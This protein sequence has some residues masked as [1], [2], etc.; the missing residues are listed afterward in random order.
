MASKNEAESKIL[1]ISIWG[2]LTFSVIGV[3]FGVVFSSE[4]IL[5]EGLFSLFSVIT[6]YITL[7]I[8]QYIHKKDRFNF[9][10]GK[11]TLEPMV[12]LIQYL[13]LS[14]FLVYALWDAIYGLATGGSDVHLLGAILYLVVSI[15]V[16]YVIVG[17]MKKI[18]KEN[19]SPLIDS[20]VFQWEISIKQSFYALASYI[21]TYILVL[22]S[23]TGIIPYIDPA[24]VIIFV[25][26]TFVSVIKEI[27]KAFKEIIGMRSI[28]KHLSDEIE[29]KIQKIV[30]QYQI[31][32]YYL[33]VNKVGS[34]ITI[35]IDFLVDRD[36]AFGS[37]H[38][39][40]QI[41]DEIEKLLEITDYELWLTIGFT[42]KH[43]WVK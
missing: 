25:L 30:T 39:Q 1:R 24:L 43:K 9:P 20:E 32:N 42:T 10:F 41:R 28:S 37:V 27:V 33:R 36:F 6:S 40:D 2:L 26:L 23:F 29:V 17:R 38:Q 12:V 8:S 21:L 19:H 15:L 13:L 14:V 11:E 4:V 35:E 34:T 22:L 3:V 5:F 7:K 31:Q 16:L 18:A